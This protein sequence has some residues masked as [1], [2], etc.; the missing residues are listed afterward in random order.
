MADWILGNRKRRL[1]TV[2][3][4][5]GLTVMGAA[6][7][8]YRRTST[9]KTDDA[10]IESRVIPISCRVSGPI[11]Q[12]FVSDNEA[13]AAGQ[14][15]AEI[16]ASDYQVRVDRAKAKVSAA[17]ARYREAEV[18]L[19]LAKA[20]APA[21]LDEARKELSVS[22][23]IEREMDAILLSAEAEQERAAADFQRM[24]LLLRKGTISQSQFE[25]AAAEAKS[26]E[27]KVRAANKRIEAGTA[28]VA[29]AHAKVRSAD[30]LTL[31]IESLEAAAERRRAELD[32]AQA[33]LR[34]AELNLSYT[35][36]YA[37]E[38]G[39]IT[40]KVVEA[41]TYVRTGMA[42]FMLVG[43]DAWIV[44]N[45]KETQLARIRPTQPVT[46]HIDAFPTQLFS[47]QIDSIQAGTGT[48]FSLLPPENATGNYIKVVQRIPVKILL[49]NTPTSNVRLVPGMSAVVE[50]KVKVR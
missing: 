23:A 36:I 50:V 32:L 42:M 9:E 12:L 24:R 34:Q 1:S 45:F 37:P 38:S 29:K 49:N 10:F 3:M 8:W 28:G 6:D 46:V 15:L 47:G 4:L 2:F 31:Q 33:E 20:T 48:R 26:T 13:V 44:A 5:V 17:E 21:I 25:Q 7:F 14:L 11:R 16:D 27:A 35:K 43:Q 22:K 40:K 18:R 41:G 19:N 39:W 30:T